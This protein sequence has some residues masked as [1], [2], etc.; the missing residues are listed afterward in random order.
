[1]HARQWYD[2]NL[3]RQWSYG[4]WTI[5]P[6]RK[7]SLVSLG[8]QCQRRN[9]PSNWQAPQWPSHWAGVLVR[10]APRLSSTVSIRVQRQRIPRRPVSK[11]R[12]GKTSSRSFPAHN[13]KTP[14]PNGNN[15]FSNLE[16][17]LNTHIYVRILVV[18][19]KWHKIETIKTKTGKWF[20][21]WNS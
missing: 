16:A 14:K 21:L 1:M 7:H 18:K 20:S 6:N 15:R 17:F 19:R 4:V 13:Q 5:N 11:L 10:I 3:Q 12:I 2:Y 9:W 8:I